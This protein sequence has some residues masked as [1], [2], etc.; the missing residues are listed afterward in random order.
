MEKNE[1]KGSK[2]SLKKK[3]DRLHLTSERLTLLKNGPAFLPGI[4]IIEQN[5]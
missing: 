3:L 1:L 5:R 4:I 2:P